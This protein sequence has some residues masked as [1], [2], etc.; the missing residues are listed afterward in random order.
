MM[1]R[2]LMGFLLLLCLAMPLNAAFLEHETV[3]LPTDGREVKTSSPLEEYRP[4]VV[5]I[6][7]PF[8]LRPLWLNYNDQYA[9]RLSG[10]P[11]RME[12]MISPWK[13]GADMHEMAISYLGKGEVLG[14]RL[15]KNLA[16]V[17]PK[18]TVTVAAKPKPAPTRPLSTALPTGAAAHQTGGSWGLALALVGG[19]GV[20]AV[21]TFRVVRWGYRRMEVEQCRI[22][23]ERR[24][25]EAATQESHMKEQAAPWVARAH[26]ERAFLDPHFQRSFAR[27]RAVE[28]LDGEDAWIADYQTV[29]QDEALYAFLRTHDTSGVDVPAWLDARMKIIDLAKKAMVGLLPDE[30]PPEA[31]PEHP[32]AEQ[33]EHERI[34]AQARELQQQVELERNF[35]DPTYQE[36]YARKYAGEILNGWGRG[37]FSDYQALRADHALMA[38]LQEEFPEVVAFHEAR[39]EVFRIAQRLDVAPPPE[40]PPVTPDE[41]RRKVTNYR[42][43]W[44][45]WRETKAQ[46]FIAQRLQQL[47]MLRAFEEDLAQYDLDEDER[48]RLLQEF[49][50]ELDLID[51]PKPKKKPDEDKEDNDEDDEGFATIRPSR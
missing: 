6:R 32:S 9:I 1:L 31:P 47:E 18:A 42:Q 7:S 44:L 14:V 10:R 36:D 46:D 30:P 29:I 38:R 8:D 35:L 15:S 21:V 5:T 23:L 2:V 26:G 27:S 43:K 33:L 19:L 34:S 51:P 39:L 22:E 4:Y 40:K 3:E 24:H 17:I 48:E 12:E 50:Q 16:H 28:I 13:Y 20:G 45:N 25:A 11:F 49:R 41:W 37:W